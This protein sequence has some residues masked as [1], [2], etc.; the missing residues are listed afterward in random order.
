MT[1][2]RSSVEHHWA[3]TWIAGPDSGRTVVLADGRHL[4][5]RSRVGRTN[6]PI[7]ADDPQLETH[8]AA[9]DLTDAGQVGRRALAGL[10][11]DA[12]ST[13]RGETVVEVGAGLLAVSRL[14]AL[15]AAPTA[16]D[17]VPTRKGVVSRTPRVSLPA[18]PPPVRV[19]AAEPAPPR[20]TSGLLPA[21]VA[22]GGAAL[23]ALILDQPMFVLFG[24]LGATVAVAS[25]ITQRLAERRAARRRRDA[26]VREHARFAAELDEHLRRRIAVLRAS[27]ITVEH[28]WHVVH[29]TSDELW[30]RRRSDADMACVSLGVA[31]L[32]VDAA[33]DGELPPGD[34]SAT[35]RFELEPAMV[36]LAGGARLAIHA[37]PDDGQ[38]L[39]RAL[40][41]QLVV[42]VG[43]A[44]LGVIVVTEQP[45]RWRWLAGAP[46]AMGSCGLTIVGP[47]TAGDEVLGPL[48]MTSD[49]TSDP[50]TN[51]DTRP[52]DRAPVGRHHVVITD[53]A[54]EAVASTTLCRRVIHRTGAA[55]VVICGRDESTPQWCTSVVHVGRSMRG[56]WQPS[57]TD[58]LAIPV[59]LAGVTET[60]AR[61]VVDALRSLIDPEDDAGTAARIPDEVS[62]TALLPAFSSEDPAS[63]IAAGWVTGG[64]DPRPVAPCGVGVDGIVSLDL[65]ADGPHVLV[66]GTTGAG[67]SELLR[68]LVYG[69][70]ASCSPDY[71]AMVLVDYKGGAT[72]DACA[73]LPHVAAVVTDLDDH[74]AERA[75]RS[76]RAELARREAVL[77]QTGSADIAEHRAK[78]NGQRLA[79]LVVVID[80]FAALAG[81]LPGFLTALVG[82]A[83]RGRS[84][85]VHLVLATQRPHGVLSDDIRANT[86]ARIALRLLDRDDA[87]DVVGVTTPAG[88]PRTTP[89][90]GIIRLGDG[91]HTVFQVASSSTDAERLGAAIAAAT[92]IVGASPPA[93]PWQPSLDTAGA[94]ASCHA[95]G[96]ID[97]PDHQRLEDLHWDRRRGPLLVVG[98]RR[99][100]TTSTLCTV[101]AAAL[102]HAVA[103]AEV[104]ALRPPI[105]L[106]VID[107]SGNAA[108]G[109]LGDH[110]WCAGVVAGH[111][112]EGIRRVLGRA[113]TLIAA[114]RDQLTQT[115]TADLPDMLLAIDGLDVLRAALG[116]T[117]H[118]DLR[119][120][121][122]EAVA[123]GT[124]GGVHVVATC[125]APTALSVSLLT[126]FAEI[127]AGALHDPSDA[128]A[129]GLRPAQALSGEHVPAGRVMLCRRGLEAQV[130][131]P[132]IPPFSAASPHGRATPI[133]PLPSRIR[134][135]DLAEH[136]V[137]HV[138]GVRF[139]PA[140]D[141]DAPAILPMDESIAHALILGPPRSG[142][143]TALATLRA[144]WAS[145][146]P[147]GTVIHVAPRHG[148]GFDR[149]L[150]ERR[151]AV[152][153][154]NDTP[155]SALL[156]AVDDA[157]SVD[158]QDGLVESLI[159]R[160]RPDV[161]VIA[162]GTPDALRR[163][164]GHWTV[165]LRSVRR[166][167]LAA[168]C[169]DSDADLVGATL[170]RR[171]PIPW[172][173]GLMYLLDNGSL[174]LCQIAVSG[175]VPDR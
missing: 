80:E 167:L 70:A 7:H 107:A 20:Q 79:R 58:P 162:A 71:L 66:A 54:N 55:L 156:V 141:R 44:D 45:A 36:D 161:A 31:T 88:F 136:A 171:C 61:H 112:V 9:L 100:G 106:M 22:L 27:T 119:A 5:G 21:T 18:D 169:T 10:V 28:A 40:L 4:I 95:V 57:T 126:H 23:I 6:C 134:C 132:R 86:N 29:S 15:R 81:E 47:D 102:D 73:H 34:L 121:L 37:T 149:T 108:L 147:H 93:P 130:S 138:V 30:Q 105:Q 94:P 91:E 142:R 2:D 153:G 128:G 25:W 101:V 75:L 145:A 82:V 99:S 51:A 14:G 46:H 175:P 19:P 144:A 60:A 127:W 146:H 32:C 17:G 148:H 1:P 68:T 77:R 33:L 103:V 96:L 109:S 83:Q 42:M 165:P 170:P 116:G 67:K 164:Y 114:R 64:P 76:L 104:P 62:L 139:D 150:L 166:G 13:S 12:R 39:C 8:H 98:R 56:R 97:D 50:A 74:L 52:G 26:A 174:S 151:L 123:Y 49:R 3:A 65:V 90:R 84:L 155:Q 63:A 53:V 59:R 48:D 172:R 11:G 133:T 92:G 110:P 173:P 168:S 111:D 69:W 137:G 154:T 122:D 131:P 163:L 41:V 125:T 159:T 124:A 35:A 140:A 113:G 16:P 117:E 38:A 24:A 89:G 120:A 78:P 160:R 152:A 85:G 72:F 135:V 87:V 157:E 143:T 43:P 129:L 158:D 115:E 118:D